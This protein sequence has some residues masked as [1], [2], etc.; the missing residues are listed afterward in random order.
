MISDF[1][2]IPSVNSGPVIVKKVIKGMV[3]SLSREKKTSDSNLAK[4]ES[5]LI[6]SYV[7]EV[8]LK[9]L[10]A[11]QNE[12]IGELRLSLFIMSYA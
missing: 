6:A 2:E 9:R 5:R 10:Q 7:P 12:W 11:S 8:V 3:P 4:P 1:K